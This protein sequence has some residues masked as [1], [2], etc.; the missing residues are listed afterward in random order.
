MTHIGLLHDD[1]RVRDLYRAI[2][3]A[4]GHGVIEAG[5][6]AGL[7]DPSITMCDLVIA[8]AAD[9]VSGLVRLKP[10]FGVGSPVL[11]CL[12]DDPSPD[13]ERW[14]HD[15]GVARVLQGPVSLRAVVDAVAA[16]LPASRRDPSR[17]AL[18][19]ARV[20]IDSADPSPSSFQVRG[21]IDR[22]G[23]HLLLTD[24]EVEVALHCFPRREG[25]RLRGVVLGP[26]EP[27]LAH[28]T[29]EVADRAFRT[30]TDAAGAFEFEQIPLGSAD[31]H[32]RGREWSLQAHLDL[33]AG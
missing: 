4:R 19:S 13:R 2:L 5:L 7:A 1:P 11:V 10:L 23:R 6:N 30:R 28:V 17:P 9:G 29:V 33:A 32:V 8:Q 15:H 25:I 22:G 12:D 16:E 18:R 21:A 31:L 24:D 27:I 3:E 20:D 14:L 26:V